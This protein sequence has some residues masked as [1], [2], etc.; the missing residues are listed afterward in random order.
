VSLPARFT[1][2]P[3]DPPYDPGRSQ[4][5]PERQPAPKRIGDLHHAWCAVWRRRASYFATVLT[6]A[7]LLLVGCAATLPPWPTEGWRSPALD[8]LSDSVSVLAAEAARLPGLGTALGWLPGTPAQ[9]LTIAGLGIVLIHLFFF[10][11]RALR[12]LIDDRAEYAL[13][14]HKDAATIPAPRTELIDHLAGFARTSKLITGFYRLLARELIPNIIGVA[15]LLTLGPI[16]IICMLLEDLMRPS[17][18]VQGRSDDVL[19]PAH[20]AS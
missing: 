16:M 11:S 3:Q 13:R 7:I 6:T 19:P 9:E 17:A 18:P 4:V 2:V 1:V 10:R 8:A 20:T 15:L 12:Q 14:D 5:T